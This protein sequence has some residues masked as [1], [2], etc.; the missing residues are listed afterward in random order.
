MTAA[1][2]T[3]TGTDIGKTYVTCGLI[4]HYRRAGRAVDARKPVISGFDPAAPAA[5]DTGALLAALG[6]PVSAAEIERVSPWRFRAPLSPDMAAAREQRTLDFDRMVQH[7]R[8]AI[9]ARSGVLLIEGVGGVM[10]PLDATR[11]VL[12]WMQALRLPVVLVTGSYLGAI[13]HTL[14]ALHVL[15]QRNLKVAAIV[16]S[17]SEAGTV[18]LDE[19]VA[20]MARFSDALAIV[21]LPR[22][23]DEKTG[24]AVFARIA[25]LTERPD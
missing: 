6:R 18:P 17:E 3:A 11:T 21:A 24:A 22:N 20:A 25:G 13:S 9:D 14:T 16:V 1:F 15:V 4:R 8:D 19:T 23:P 7:C 10:V 12:D 5:S 2:I